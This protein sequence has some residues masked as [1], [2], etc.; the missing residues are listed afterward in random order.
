MLAGLKREWR[1]FEGERPGKRF[2]QHYRR[3]HDVKRSKANVVLYWLGALVAFAIGVVLVFIPGPAVLFFLIAA[4]LVA[5]QALWLA[6]LLDRGELRLRAWARR[7]KGWWRRRALVAR[8]G[9]IAGAIGIAGAFIA[10]SVYLF[11]L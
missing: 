8:I 7:F 2:E 10:G 11:L 4:A 3:T 1:A 9:M 5:T 6:R